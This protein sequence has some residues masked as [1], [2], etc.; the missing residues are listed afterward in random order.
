MSSAMDEDV[1]VI[2]LPLLLA[3]VSCLPVAVTIG[4]HCSQCIPVVLVET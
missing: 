3:N 2:K 1:E 4:E